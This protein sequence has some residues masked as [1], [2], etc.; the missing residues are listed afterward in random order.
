MCVCMHMRVNMCKV[1]A[2]VS[3]MVHKAR[4]GGQ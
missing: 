4:S 1:L 2:S 3:D